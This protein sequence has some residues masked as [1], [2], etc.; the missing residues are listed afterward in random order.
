MMRLFHR[1]LPLSVIVC[2]PAF[3]CYLVREKVLRFSFV[4]DA[5]EES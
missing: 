1:W 3:F 5:Y 4:S 2:D